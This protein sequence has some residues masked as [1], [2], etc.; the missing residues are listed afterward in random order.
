MVRWS[1]AWLI[2][3]NVGLFVKDGICEGLQPRSILQRKRHFCSVAL[4]TSVHAVGHGLLS[5]LHQWTFFFPLKLYT[6]NTRIVESSRERSMPFDPARPCGFDGILGGSKDRMTC[7]VRSTGQLL[8]FWC[9]Q[10]V[11][12]SRYLLNSWTDTD[13]R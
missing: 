6:S 1:D 9:G 5:S 8:L 12:A 2:D 7:V 3:L 10:E 11:H 13:L 4:Y